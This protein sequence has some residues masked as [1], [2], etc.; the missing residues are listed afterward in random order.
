M[1]FFNAI[2]VPAVGMAGGLCLMWRQG[3]DLDLISASKSVITVFFHEPQVSQ[4]R[5]FWAHFTSEVM[6]RGGIWACIGDLNCLLS[7]EE[8]MGGSNFWTYDG[9]GLRK[10]IFQTGSVNV[11]CS[12]GM[13]T[14]TNERDLEH[15]V[16]ERLDRVVCIPQW[17]I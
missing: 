3:I 11:G 16:K 9:S 15:L 14:W 10:F 6:T 8:K 4:R 17:M 5:L 12:G 13:F 2:V 1:G 7:M